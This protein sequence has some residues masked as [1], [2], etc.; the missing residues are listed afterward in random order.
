MNISEEECLKRL[1]DF[2]EK[3]PCINRADYCAITGMN[4][5][6]ARQLNLSIEK[7]VI[8]KIWDWENGSVYTCCVNS[9][10]RFLQRI[11]L[12]IPKYRL[13]K[14]LLIILSWSNR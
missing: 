8:Q 6:Q 11:I 3:H 12:I 4:K 10:F 9:Y 2:L 1:Q 5:T 13:K 7:G 14:L